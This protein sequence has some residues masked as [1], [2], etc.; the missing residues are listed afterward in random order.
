MRAAR[1]RAGRRSSAC[2]PSS[3]ST[4]KCVTASR[5]VSV[6]SERRV[7]SRRSRP[8]GASIRPRPRARPAAHEREV[9]RARARA[10]CTSVLQ[11]RVRLLACA[12]RRAGPR[13]RGRAGGRCPAAPRPRRPR[14][15]RASPC[16][17]VPVAWPG[18]GWTTTPG[19]L[20]DDEQ[21]LVLVG[22]PERHVL[23]LEPGAAG[24]GRPSSSTSSPPSSRWLFA[25]AAPSTSDGARVEQP[26]GGA[27]RADLRQRG[28]EAVE[29]LARG[30]RQER[31]V[32]SVTRAA[33]LAVGGDE[34]DEQDRDADHDE[35]V[36]EVERRPVAEVEE[37][38]HVPEPD[39][40]E[41]VRGRCRRSAGRARPAAAGAA[42][43]SGRRRRASSRP[44][45]RSARSRRP[46][47]SRRARRRC[48]EFWTWWI[49]NGP[50]TC[51]SSSSASWLAT[52]ML[53]QLVGDDAAI[54]TA[55]RPTQCAARAA[56]DR[57]ATEIGVSPSVREPDAERRSVRGA[58]S[59]NL[60]PASACRRCTAS[61]TAAPRAAPRPIGLPQLRADAERALVDALQRRVDLVEHV[62]RVVLER[63]R[64]SRGR[65]WRWR[66]RRDGCRLGAPRARPRASLGS[67][68]QVLDRVLDAL[69]LLEQRCGSARCRSCSWP[70]LEPPLGLGRVDAVAADDLSRAAWP[71]TTR[72][73]ARGTSRRSRE[74]VGRRRRSRV[75]ARARRDAH[76]PGVAVP[77]DELRARA[78]G[79]TRS[80]RRVGGS[81]ISPS[82]GSAACGSGCLARRPSASS[83]ASSAASQQGAHLARLGDAAARAPRAAWRVIVR[84][85]A[86]ASATIELGLAL[87]L[88]LQLVRGCSAETSVVRS[89]ASSSR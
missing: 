32:S 72:D 70:L 41:Q 24:F 63:G 83:T 89:S 4:S 80:R 43:P 46:S 61:P 69:A 1:S 30:R 59:L 51:T 84:A 62:L 11:P 38:G 17:S 3:R 35:A 60:A 40:V 68:V 47:R 31:D 53:R 20:V 87:R 50:T 39:P 81:A 8:I 36:G 28:E 19:R 64:R 14:P 74:Q 79:E 49:E 86:W 54:A 82:I 12:R 48:P 33:R 67:P 75:R 56:S 7:G 85:S 44:R 37:V 65:R 15:G 57:S 73:R 71:E 22:D 2:R 6:S 77:A 16:T 25:R 34:R 88:V 58:G 9:A 76:L 45:A 21:V 78:P 13:C 29:P 26:L 5:G 23:A 55:P 27:A 52:T 66:R 42:R 10:R 18:A